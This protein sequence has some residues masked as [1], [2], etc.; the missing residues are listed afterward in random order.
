MLRYRVIKQELL[1]IIRKCKPLEK[2]PSRVTLCHRLDTSRATLDKA[3]KELEAEGIL[4]C[5][6]DSGTYVAVPHGYDVRSAVHQITKITNARVADMGG[7]S[8]NK[9][10][11]DSNAWVWEVGNGAS[12]VARINL[13]GIWGW[14]KTVRDMVRYI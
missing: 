11:Y 14:A 13:F 1:D 5:K 9:P 12:I 4:F 8:K 6:D 3:I 10:G 7:T 2:L